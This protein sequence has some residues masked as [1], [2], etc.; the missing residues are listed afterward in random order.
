[1]N[2]HDKAVLVLVSIFTFLALISLYGLGCMAWEIIK[3]VRGD[4]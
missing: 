3:R 4:R 1:M 2:D